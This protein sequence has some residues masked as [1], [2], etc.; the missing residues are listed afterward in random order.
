[1]TSPREAY[2]E[3]LEGLLSE[4]CFLLGTQATDGPSPAVARWLNRATEAVGPRC[5]E[6]WAHITPARDQTSME[7]WGCGAMVEI[8]DYEH[9]RY[10][11]SYRLAAHQ[12]LSCG[13]SGPCPGGPNDAPAE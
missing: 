4:A 1:M 6:S 2:V 5:E 13:R 12:R 9:P 7:C 8:E 10:G 3:K 11:T